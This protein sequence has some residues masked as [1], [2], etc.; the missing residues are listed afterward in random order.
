MTILYKLMN[1]WKSLFSF[2]IVIV[3][4]AVVVVVVIAALVK[5]TTEWIPIHEH[6]IL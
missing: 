5:H 6:W 2:C 1:G 3:V 4:V